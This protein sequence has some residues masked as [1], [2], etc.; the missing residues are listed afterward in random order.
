MRQRSTLA[1]QCQE[2]RKQHLLESNTM[3]VVHQLHEAEAGARFENHARTLQQRFQAKSSSMV[4][5]DPFPNYEHDPTQALNLFWE[6]SAILRFEHDLSSNELR[7]EIRESRI[8]DSTKQSCLEN[9][10][11]ER[12]PNLLEF[13]TCAVCFSSSFDHNEMV[14]PDML[15]MLDRIITR[16]YALISVVYSLSSFQ[17]YLH[18]KIRFFCIV[19]PL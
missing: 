9:F 4:F 1:F 11:R 6:T 3:E 17:S 19:I 14:P 2:D 15:S 10:K 8:S 7:H 12:D 5:E 18:L 16:Y 13:N